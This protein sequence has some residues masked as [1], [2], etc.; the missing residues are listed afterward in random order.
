MSNELAPRWVY[1]FIEHTKISKDNFYQYYSD[2]NDLENEIWSN[3]FQSTL[4]V[5]QKDPTYQSFSL[6]EK[7]LAFCY[8]LVEVMQ[9]HRVALVSILAKDYYSR[10]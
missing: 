2:L 6:R 8:T 10:S 9:D 4:E 5:L 3:I 7:L 1:K